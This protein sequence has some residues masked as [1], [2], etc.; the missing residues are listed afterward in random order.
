MNKPRIFVPRAV[1]PEAMELLRTRCQVEVGPEGGLPHAELVKA[2]RGYDGIFTPVITLNAEVIDAMAPTCKVIS[3]FGVGF[4]HVDIAA[5]TRNGIWVT[6]NPGFVT[7]DTA[8][9][10]FALLLG[11]ARRLREC[12]LYVRSGTT[13]WPLNSLIGLR[14]S[15]KTLGLVG[16]G[17]IALAVATRAA[18]FGMALI[19]GFI[20][21]WPLGLAILAYMI[22]SKRMFSSC[23][24]RHHHRGNGRSF[25]APTGN[26]AFDAYRE[27]TLKRLEDEHDEFVDFLQKLRE[28]KDKAEFDQFMADNITDDMA[29]DHLT[30]TYG[31]V[32][33]K[34]LS[35]GYPQMA[36]N[37]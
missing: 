2:V 13:P 10:A 12:D 37:P 6:H 22:W 17:R 11:V 31:E 33:Q 36:V 19:L 27:E 15:G 26:I 32:F 5:A 20:A 1:V 24:H 14:V 30:S 7:E 4:D 34:D 21:V 23:R 3:C 29:R 18:G 25:S 8:D 16:S 28:A 35:A 9:M